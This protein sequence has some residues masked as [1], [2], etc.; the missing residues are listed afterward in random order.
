MRLACLNIVISLANQLSDV[1]VNLHHK[2]ASDRVVKILFDKHYGKSS[3]DVLT[4]VG[5]DVIRM[6]A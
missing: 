1:V 3:K 2:Q 5:M 4:S 6:S